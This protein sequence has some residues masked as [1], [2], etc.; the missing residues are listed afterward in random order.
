[1][2]PTVNWRV[3]ISGKGITIQ[4]QEKKISVLVQQRVCVHAK[5]GHGPP[6]GRLPERATLAAGHGLV[7]FS[8]ADGG[9]QL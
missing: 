6:G 8:L 1:M 4:S 9:P 3:C 5:Q 7:D 2:R